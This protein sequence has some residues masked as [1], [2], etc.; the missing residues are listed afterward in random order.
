[1]T[2]TLE[3]VRTRFAWQTRVGAVCVAVALVAILVAMLPRLPQP[4]AY[5]DFADQRAFAGIPNFLDVVS[6]LA[7]LLAGATGMRHWARSTVA[8]RVFFVAA[9]GIG[10][11]S[12]WYHWAPDNARLLWDRLPM[13][14]AFGALV[15]AVIG[16]RISARGGPL[17]LAPL[18]FGAAASVVLWYGSE[19]AGAGDLRPYL[20][21]QGGA[22]LAV[23]LVLLLFA[24]RHT[25]GGAVAVALGCYAL[26]MIC[27]EIL[28]ARIYAGTG[29]VSGHTI[30]HLLAGAAIGQLA[31]MIRLR[32]PL[33]Q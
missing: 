25:H 16:D 1:M 22:A 9:A 11:G 10:C 24:A 2:S 3:R 15:A 13:A 29:A 5:H 31:R 30:K 28:D 17:L 21:V 4:L 12:A 27:G 23:A 7:I 26:A 32:A 33:E 18:M 8:W 14:L 19:L 20:F 6:N